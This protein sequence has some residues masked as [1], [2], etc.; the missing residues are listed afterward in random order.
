MIQGLEN[1][2]LW[3]RLN[4]FVNQIVNFLYKVISLTYLVGKLDPI[5]ALFKQR[6]ELLCSNLD[7]SISNVGTFKIWGLMLDLWIKVVPAGYNDYGISKKIN[8]W[9][10]DLQDLTSGS[11]AQK[12]QVSFLSKIKNKKLVSS[13]IFMRTSQD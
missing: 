6:S 3:Q 5:V 2:S 13:G 12:D 4:S 10:W 7:I 9:S 8:A 1:Q 11:L